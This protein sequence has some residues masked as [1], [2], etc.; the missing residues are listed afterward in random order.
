MWF[1]Y[2]TN[3]QYFHIY[4]AFVPY[5]FDSIWFKSHINSNL[6]DGLTCNIEYGDW[7]IQYLFFAHHWISN[8][9]LSVF[10][11]FGQYIFDFTWHTVPS[12]IEYHRWKL[13]IW[14]FDFS[15]D[16]STAPTPCKGSK[17]GGDDDYVDEW[18]KLVQ[19]CNHPVTLEEMQKS[20]FYLGGPVEGFLHKKK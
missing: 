17:S 18:T 20:S 15:G 6:H 14:I 13:N 12:K 5:I 16:R 1:L 10:L 8:M 11:D 4:M 3:K 19:H 2:H 9:L 7:H